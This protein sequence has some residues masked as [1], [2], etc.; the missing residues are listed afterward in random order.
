MASLFDVTAFGSQL[1]LQSLAQAVE[2]AG[3]GL[4]IVSSGDGATL[5]DLTLTQLARCYDVAARHKPQT[6]LVPL[7]PRAGWTISTR[8]T[9]QRFSTTYHLQIA[10]QGK[11]PYRQSGSPARCAISSGA[12][13]SAAQLIHSCYFCTSS[14]FDTI[15][16][17]GIIST[18]P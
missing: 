7:L 9:L 5:L 12:S 6:N 14:T 1:D 10:P 11:L 16:T 15:I 13:S 2:Q 17:T 8:S 18:N 4:Y 3:Q